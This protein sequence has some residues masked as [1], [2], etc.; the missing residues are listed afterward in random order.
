MKVVVIADYLSCDTSVSSTENMTSDLK[1]TMISSILVAEGGTKL[2]I[3]QGS[4]GCTITLPY[5]LIQF[6]LPELTALV[7]DQMC[8]QL[9]DVMVILPD[10]H[11]ETL[12]IFKEL[13]TVG[14]SSP[15][16]LKA[17]ERLL[18]FAPNLELGKIECHDPLSISG[19]NENDGSNDNR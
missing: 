1:Q 8:C 3:F 13:V 16:G 5:F 4:S 11:Y 18:R 7:S 6:V 9:N 10:V 2:C 17:L 14:Q 19:E 12:V 15:V